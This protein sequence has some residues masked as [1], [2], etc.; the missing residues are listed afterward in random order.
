MHCIHFVKFLNIKLLL[1]AHLISHWPR[2]PLIRNAIQ[3]YSTLFSLVYKL[4]QILIKGLN[5]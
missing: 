4:H 2:V 3:I 1:N 5:A